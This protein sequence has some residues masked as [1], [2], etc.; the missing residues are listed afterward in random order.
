MDRIKKIKIKQ[1]DGTMS[2]Y[3]PIGADASNI[4]LNYNG[5]NVE[6]TLKKKPYYYNCV[7]DMKADDALKIGDMVITLGYYTAN[8][9]GGAEYKIVN[10]NYTD[11]GG[12][13]HEL[14]N[15]LFAELI[16]INEE[17]FI[18]TKFLNL[19]IEESVANGIDNFNKIKII[20]EKGYNLIFD[21]L[22]PFVNKQ[23]SNNFN[24]NRTVKI[25]GESDNCG[26]KFI[27][28]VNENYY[29]N[30]ENGDFYCEKLIFN[31]IGKNVVFI[32]N[33]TQKDNKFKYGSIEALNCTF[34]GDFRFVALFQTTIYEAD[35]NWGCGFINVNNCYIENNASSFIYISRMPSKIVKFNNNRVHNFSHCLIFQMWNENETFSGEDV[36]IARRYI[37]G[38]EIKN[39]YVINDDDWFGV[40]SAYYSIVATKS[41]QSI[42]EN[43]IVIG[44]KSIDGS[45]SLNPFYLIGTLI[46]VQ[47]NYCKNNINFSGYINMIF[48]S[49]AGEDAVRSYINNTFILDENWANT[50]NNN[51]E[52]PYTAEQLKNNLK[53]QIFQNAITTKQFNIINNKINYPYLINQTT[54]SD[55]E[56]FIFNENNI[57]CKEWEGY[58]FRPG[59]SNTNI[60]I[61]RNYIEASNHNINNFALVATGY[62]FNNLNM[63]I[64]DNFIRVNND[65]FQVIGITPPDSQDNIIIPFKTLHFENNIIYNFGS[66][67]TTNFLLSIYRGWGQ[68]GYICKNNYLYTKGKDRIWRITLGEIPME[69]DLQYEG[70]L[71]N[72]VTE[73]KYSILQFDPKQVYTKETTY[74]LTLSYDNLEEKN[75][76]FYFTIYTL[77][78]KNYISYKDTTGSQVAKI[79]YDTTSLT[80]DYI[81]CETDSSITD[82]CRIQNTATYCQIYF[83]KSL[84]NDGENKVKV[85]I[86]TVNIK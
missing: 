60:S 25:I 56:D 80:S 83:N 76:I 19:A 67:A 75:L 37:D 79:M 22:Y 46:K 10:G 69:Y 49:K 61:C 85:N 57:Q 4:D 8:D 34:I 2:D 78:N 52:N 26:F 18:N 44:M 13:Y 27:D 28:N 24:I 16:N 77:N 38:V 66:P 32:S 30:L 82:L 43:N 63:S 41:R 65:G 74:K 86:K 15:D 84:F 42:V 12:S 11:D 71:F 21:N 23:Y 62:S 47:N 31:N 70:T 50:I 51:L 35:N 53:T 36:I 81:Y 64:C 55:L 45:T 14:E 73:L 54:T 6:N 3:Y 48:K 59:I 1:Q 33:Y 29:F 39:N 20:L 5:S 7:A 40:G 72:S 9:G 68:E 17:K 58:L